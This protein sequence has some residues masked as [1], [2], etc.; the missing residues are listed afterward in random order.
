MHSLH[1]FF[2]DPR[3]NLW[4]MYFLSL[5]KDETLTDPLM[6][7]DALGKVYPW[8][9]MLVATEPPQKG[10]TSEDCLLTSRSAAGEANP[11]KN[12]RPLAAG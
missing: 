4:I 12:L 8:T 3:R 1:Q 2:P 11:S 7:V 10:L 6:N 9:G 5:G